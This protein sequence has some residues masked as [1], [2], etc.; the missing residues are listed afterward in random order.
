VLKNIFLS[1]MVMLFD[2]RVFITLLFPLFFN[3]VSAAILAE[4]HDEITPLSRLKTLSLTAV[5]DAAERRTPETSL[6]AAD[7]KKRVAAEGYRRSWL[8]D[9]IRV[10][11]NYQN[12]RL[13]TDQG[14]E[15]L[16]LGVSVP[17]RRWGSEAKANRVLLLAGEVLQHKK[18]LLRLRLS[19]QV[20]ESL[21]ALI[22]SHNDYELVAAEWQTAQR[23]EADV[24]K[25]VKL[26]ELARRDLLLAQG[27]SLARRGEL[28]HAQELFQH[29]QHN[30]RT[31][32][33]LKAVPQ[34]FQ[35]QLV[36][37]QD[38]PLLH[39]EQLL[40]LSSARG[41]AQ[42]QA[43]LKR[44]ESKGGP[45]LQ[46]N[47]RQEQF[48]YQSTSLKSMGLG[49]SLPLG[50][51]SR[52]RQVA[53]EGLYGVA[54]AERQLAEQR[55]LLR[56]ELHHAEHAL[57]LSG[58][59]LKVARQRH[60]LAQKNVRLTVSAFRAGEVDLVELLRIKARAF[61]V[62]RNVKLHQLQLQRE[63]SR[64]NQASGVSL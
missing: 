20:R 3:S 7:A 56:S 23:L 29:A 62:E 47:L 35:E 45:E 24:Q 58:E 16:E 15:E 55:R 61:V 46:F 53:A 42:A 59:A 57:K 21:W 19:G 50:G 14:M 17:L 2:V 38:D 64:L 40:L 5:V 60:D 41:Q 31:L 12:D 11:V 36:V 32:T 63:I 18:A 43:A 33:G 8:S 44:L 10:G 26:G 49:V 28:F 25:R 4:S 34:Q 6:L 37:F 27:E 1:E 52:E 9:S 13:L 39:H 48:D 54:Q 51:G 22:I 30:Y